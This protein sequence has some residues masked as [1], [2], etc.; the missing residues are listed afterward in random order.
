[1]RYL[2]FELSESGDGV[3]TL[4]AMASTAAAQ[5]EAVMA[6]VQQVLAWAIRHFPHTQGAVD[7]GN[8]WQHD[9]QLS[10]QAGVQG[11]TWHSVTLTLSASDAFVAEFLPAFGTTPD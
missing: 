11:R 8:D 6:E 4:E 3:T 1:M 10:L 9:L 2:H 7:D 5:H